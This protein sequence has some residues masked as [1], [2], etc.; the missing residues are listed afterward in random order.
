M[1]RTATGIFEVA[2]VPQ[3]DRE[4][5]MFGRMTIDK[6]F[7]GA[8]EGTSQGQM[9]S[10]G[11]AVKGSAGYVAME[12]VEGTLDGK[13]GS[14]A[15]QHTATMNRGEPS[16]TI[17][18]V[19]DSGTDELEGISGTLNIRREDGKHFYDLTYTLKK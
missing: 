4:I 13:K 3:T 15:L 16:L 8:L 10:A 12:R 2:I 18:I 19:P 17:I 1:Q 11:T 9:L 6:Q 5:P 14:F 7:H